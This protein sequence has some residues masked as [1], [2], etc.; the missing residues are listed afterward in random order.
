MQQKKA[1]V[2]DMTKHQKVA[3]LIV[4]LTAG[5][6]VLAWAVPGYRIADASSAKQA[7][8]QYGENNF[9]FRAVVYQARL[10]KKLWRL[11]LASH[12]YLRERPKDPV[13]ECSFAQAYWASQQVREEVPAVDQ[14]KLAGL[15]DEA[16]RDTQ[17]AVKNM[18]KNV[19]AHLTYGFY[20]ERF[21]MG[22]GKVPL[23]Q[24]EFKKAVALTPNVGEVHAQLADAYFSS[25]PLT[26]PEVE[27]MIAEYKKAVA[28]DPR[29]TQC[30]LFLSGSYDRVQ[31]YMNERRYLN[32]Y[33]SLHPEE[34]SRSDIVAAQKHLTD[35]LGS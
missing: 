23:M 22:M 8:Q 12:D 5:L 20:L 30:Y 31:D 14:K 15:Y 27:R 3:G 29:Q 19:D 1:K 32:K 9:Q 13:R 10:D 11:A 4:L 33:L 35:K 16:V 18:P 24:A 26:H 2:A 21:V 34:A 6:A 7:V 28:L 17:D 25:G